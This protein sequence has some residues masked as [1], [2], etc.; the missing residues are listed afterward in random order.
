ML[1]FEGNKLGAT[2]IAFK[3]LPDSSLAS[4]YLS[5]VLLHFVCQYEVHVS[6]KE[7]ANYFLY[8]YGSEGCAYKFCL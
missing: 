8:T 5:V 7:L 1:F 4:F 3:T 6:F 2:R